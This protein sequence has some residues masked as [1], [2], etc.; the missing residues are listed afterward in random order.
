MSEEEKEAKAQKKVEKEKNTQAT[1]DALETGARAAATFFGGPGAGKLADIGLHLPHVRLLFKGAA[2][3][4]NRVPGVA[5]TTRRA[6]SS[7]ALKAVDAVAGGI[8]KFKAGPGVNGAA[9][10]VLGGKSANNIV[11]KDSRKSLISGGIQANSG[12]Q[13]SIVNSK[14]AEGWGESNHLKGGLKSTP[15]N[16]LHEGSPSSNKNGTKKAAFLLDNKKSFLE[17][18]KKKI[19]LIGG[20]IA[21]ILFPVFIMFMFVGNSSS[22]GSNVITKVAE[23]ED[24]GDIY[25]NEY[26]N[27]CEEEECTEEQ[28]EIIESQSKF[29]ER[30]DTVGNDYNLTAK[31]KQIIYETILYGYDIED[32]IEGKA[33]EIDDENEDENKQENVYETEKDTI[34]FLAKKF[35]D[36]EDSYYNFLL[37]E[38][39]FETKSN[40]FSAYASYARRENLDSNNIE[41]W[42]DNEKV[43]VRK[44]IIKSIKTNVASEFPEKGNN[45]TSHLVS[46]NNYFWWP[47]GGEDKPLYTGISSSYGYRTNPITGEKQSFHNGIDIPAVINTPVIASQS[48]TVT[49]TNNTCATSNSTGCGSG[50][51]NRVE[52]TD[53]NGNINLYGHLAKDSIIVKV[54]DQVLQGQQIAGV[55]SSGN[56]TGPHLHF[57][58]KINGQAVNPLDYVDP[59]NPRP[60]SSGRLNYNY[61][62]YSST[63]F[64]TLLK[65]YYSRDK[66]CNSS[67][68]QYV[69]GCNSFK[70]EIL[71]NNGANILYEVAS[72]YNIN[73]ELV[74]I[75][76]MVEGYSPG[77]HYNYFGFT[78]YNTAS[79]ESC[80]KFS[81][82]ESSMNSFFKNLSQYTSLE[83]M[84]EHYAG[85]GD[86][87]YTQRSWG[88]GGC[89]YAEYIYPDGVPDRVKEICAYPED[90]C[91][92]YNTK[93]CFK[94]T[95]EDKAAFT[96]FQVRKMEEVAEKVFG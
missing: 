79:I 87:W 94:T 7:G 12:Q 17:P 31:Q 1:Q 15:S 83:N 49:A 23:G 88:L 70:S 14:T 41:S 40:Y 27:Y 34:K 74:V 25:K 93:N 16:L 18:K 81:S 26:S 58:I 65:N 6:Q 44:R 8:P 2:K 89:I 61:S 33:F 63:E 45:Y 3:V 86:Y 36:S 73:P 69:N 38:D 28:K 43:E 10:S 71:N 24:A 62:A 95:D 57:T 50:Y 68:K 72:S 35:D 78:C 20:A 29:F 47:I 64:A 19:M 77:T 96:A 66:V 48:G 80:T 13:S 53:I 76:S 42:T 92:K 11:P 52:I 85:L 67:S 21:I 30:L 54:G 22:Y 9:G 4:A 46:Q 51:G 60:K 82:F 75:R 55:G 56:S 5:T 90:F 84:S 91:T 32:L 37:T 39:Y 59:N